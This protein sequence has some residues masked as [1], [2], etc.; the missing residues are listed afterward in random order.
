MRNAAVGLALGVCL[1]SAA[2]RAGSFDPD[3][4]FR[5][6]KGAVVSLDFETETL[7]PNADPMDPPPTRKAVADALSGGFVLRLGPFEQAAFDVPLPKGAAT[8]RASVWIRGGEAV[9]AVNQAHDGK[10][11]DTVA[12]LYPTGRVTSDGWV[13]LANDHIAIDGALGKIFVGVFSPGGCDVDAIE[14]V[15]DGTVLGP[16]VTSCQG[17]GDGDACGPGRVCTFGACRR[18]NAEVP[19]I[20]ADRDAV[21]AYLANRIEFLFGPYQQRTQDLPN[22]RVAIE[23]MRHAADP[24]G[25]WNGF[26]LALRRLHDSH[27]S[28]T[29]GLASFAIRNPRPINVCFIEGDADWSHAAAP[30]DPA[31]RDVLVSHTGKLRN[32]NLHAGDRLVRVDGRHPIEWARSLVSVEWGYESAANHTTFAEH[33]AALRSAIARYAANIEVIRCDATAKT[34]GAIEKIDIVGMP[35][36]AEGEMYDPVECD[37]RPL[38]H[39]ANSPANHFNVDFSNGAEKAFF[40]IVDASDANE[41]IFGVEWDSLYTTN[42]Q[43]GIGKELSAAIAALDSQSASAAILDHRRGTGGTIAGPEIIWNFAEKKHPLTFYQA[44]QRAE[45]AQP[46]QAIGK[47]LFDAAVASKDFGVDYAGGT[48]DAPIPVAL[49]ITSDI[50]A[51]D[52]LALGL[53]G[54]PKVRLFGPYATSGAFSTRL[55]FGYWLGM[56]YTLA[57]GDSFVADGRTIN[58]TGVEPD[59]VVLPKQSDLVTGKD[60]VFEAALAWIRAQGGGG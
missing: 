35:K 57:S 12:T 41:R 34:C 19:P 26:L 4:T 42:G 46:T 54:Q 55:S 47:A 22:A 48:H 49:L 27:T 13:E 6:A 45:D 40:G 37:N 16:L 28:S 59:E 3:G 15:P 11:I 32:L 50:S 51:S 44:R 1:T 53:K 24:W 36:A 33:A 23:Q 39:L 30:S 17:I 2:A 60:T 20:P 25:Y 38:R 58:G 14:L 10:R 56:N 29:G 21:T 8:Y 18:V 9:G 52:W 43:D 7:P 5:F 31:Y